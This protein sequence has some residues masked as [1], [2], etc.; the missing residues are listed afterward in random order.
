MVEAVFDPNQEV[1]LS[2]SER[3]LIEAFQANLDASRMAGECDCS[4]KVIR[5][6]FQGGLS[7]DA[8]VQIFNPGTACGSNC[9]LFSFHASTK[10][11]ECPFPIPTSCVQNSD[12]EPVSGAVQP[13]VQLFNCPLDKGEFITLRANVNKYD[14]PVSPCATSPEISTASVTVEVEIQCVDDTANPQTLHTTSHTFIIPAN[15]FFKIARMIVDENC[16]PA[17]ITRS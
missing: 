14:D 17:F 5:A 3:K 4:I 1:P 7:T 2:V 10:I 13:N 9:P 11:D 8:L 6:Q 12:L 15:Q 16:A